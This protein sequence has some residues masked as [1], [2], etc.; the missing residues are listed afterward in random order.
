MTLR[1]NLPAPLASL[2][3]A[4][5]ALALSPIAAPPLAAAPAGNA[6][7]AAQAAHPALWRVTRGGTTI[8]LFGT[9]HA[10]PRGINWF[11]GPMAR[12]FAG[13]GEL[14]TEILDKPPEEM[15]K[16]VAARA[17]LPAG[18]N[19][20]A[21]LPPAGRRAF[22]QALRANDTPTNAFDHYQPWYAAVAL[23]TLPLLHA[24][25]DPANGVDA[26]LATRAKAMGQ[27]H[28]ALETP[29][30]QLGLF[31][32][33]P[34]TTQIRYL[35]EV[36]ANLPAVKSDLATMV[37]AWR[38]GQ[39]TRLAQLMNADE[40]DPQLR[41]LLLVGRNKAWAKWVAMQLAAPRAKPTTLFVAVGAGHL[42]GAG[43]LLEQLG[44]YG[45]RPVRLQ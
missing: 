26:Q 43:S 4:L 32:H 33:L 18:Q 20:R 28:E 35:E 7:Q 9:V 22:E 19:L 27:A 37:R 30:F 44:A 11:N 10:L 39:A 16:I 34:M 29:E 6:A 14:V 25:Y 45:I 36:L 12:A 13:S 40:D 2:L 23:S 31:A 42:A 15:A 17:L 38:A 41:Q 21:L 8:Y 5:L 3:L 24:G 1:K